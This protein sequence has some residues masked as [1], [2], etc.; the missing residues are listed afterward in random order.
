MKFLIESLQL[1]DKLNPKLFD[2]DNKLKEE[3]LDQLSLIVDKFVEELKE[4][5]IPINVIDYW[6]VG[7]NASYNYT[8]TSDIDI[9]IIADVSAV[10]RDS[11]LLKIVYDYFKTS[12]N[13][14][15]DITVKGH[16][17]ELYIEDVNS[18][19]V[20][21]GIYSLFDDKWIKFPE[22]IK[23]EDID[24]ESSELYL[25]LLSQYNNCEDPQE[26]LDKLY[27]LRKTALANEGEFG[28]A[29]LVF[30][31]FRNN[32]YIDELKD[33]IVR[34]E[35]NR[36]TLEKL[37]ESLLSEQTTPQYRE[38]FL[39]LIYFVTNNPKL[40]KL[41]QNK[42]VDLNIH[43]I[44][45][46]YK[47]YLTKNG[48]K[49]K[50]AVNNDVGNIMLMYEEDH[51]KLTSFKGDNKARDEYISH[52]VDR[53][54]AFYLIDCVPRSILYFLDKY[55]EKESLDNAVERSSQTSERDDRNTTNE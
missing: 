9:H 28:L 42:S 5:N 21:N 51:R 29:N 20:T 45:G 12:F 44:D 16:E 41:I 54:V 36:L 22:P 50:R 40:R 32:G 52:L 15:Y 25:Q 10:S 53:G 13:K 35:N 1:K 8:E 3:I 39:Q 6:L 7:S 23:V 49:R 37:D 31:A 11:G 43:H 14:K 38:M 27:L 33:A 30:K 2:S 34:S 19:C 4:E 47:E 46:D 24:V 55:V 26:L 18:A 48:T 17:V